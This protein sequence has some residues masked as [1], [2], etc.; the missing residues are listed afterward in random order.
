METFENTS[1]KN[2]LPLGNNTGQD[3]GTHDF[4]PTSL[5]RLLTQIPGGEGWCRG[6]AGLLWAAA[7]DGA[8]G[9]VVDQAWQEG[10]LLVLKEA[11]SITACRA[12]TGVVVVVGVVAGGVAADGSLISAKWAGLVVSLVFNYKKI[13]RF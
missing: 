2:P 3:H 12:Q 13:S 4:N 9:L 7:E 11:G 10:A 5:L 1:S 8:V 6:A